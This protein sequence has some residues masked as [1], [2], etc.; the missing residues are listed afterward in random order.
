M[1]LFISKSMD[2]ILKPIFS[3]FSNFYVIFIISIN[4][5]NCIKVIKLISEI[6]NI[7]K[8][9][10][11]INNKLNKLSVLKDNREA[12][13]KTIVLKCLDEKNNEENNSDKQI[14]ILRKRITK[15]NQKLNNNN[16]F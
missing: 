13:I 15:I 7:I 11:E 6:S 5:Y 16:I 2:L 10:T 8:Q 12:F 1:E 3:N 14:N 9:Q 4:I